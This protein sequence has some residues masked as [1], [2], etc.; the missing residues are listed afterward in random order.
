M[1][2]KTLHKHYSNTMRLGLHYSHCTPIEYCTMAAL[3]F[4]VHDTYRSVFIQTGQ[5]MTHL[6]RGSQYRN[7]V[8]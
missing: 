7:L 5:T 1:A 8:P 2:V 4:C 6:T 3:V